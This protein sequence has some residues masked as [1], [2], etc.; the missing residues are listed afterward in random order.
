MF[1]SYKESDHREGVLLFCVLPLIRRGPLTLQPCLRRDISRIKNDMVRGRQDAT[2]CKGNGREG[3][4]EGEEDRRLK[5][6][7]SVYIVAHI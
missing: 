1:I 4:C 2:V 5:K 6:E 7:K 3:A